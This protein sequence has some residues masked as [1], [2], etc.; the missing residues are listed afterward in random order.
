MQKTPG[1][2]SGEPRKGQTPSP[3]VQ[4]EI[5]GGQLETPE[6]QQGAAGMDVEGLDPGVGIPVDP[7]GSKSPGTRAEEKPGAGKDEARDEPE[8]EIQ[9][10][11]KE[12]SAPAVDAQESSSKGIPAG[13]T[14]GAIPGMSPSSEEAPVV[15]PGV[16][17]P[18]TEPAPPEKT[19]VPEAGKSSWETSTEKKAVPKSGDAPGKKW[20]VA[21]TERERT[22]EESIK[23][24]E[25]PG[26]IWGKAGTE[27]EKTPGKTSCKGGENSGSATGEIHVGSLVK[28]PPNKGMGAAKSDESRAAAPVNPAG[29]LKESCVGKTLLKAVVSVPDILKQRI[30]V[31]I[32]EPSLGKAGEQKIPPK[33]GLEKKIP[34]KAAAQPGT[35]NQWRGNGNSGMDAQGD[36]GK[37]SS[38]QEKDSQ[39]ESRGS[40]KQQGENGTSGTR[41]NAS[42]NQVRRAGIPVFPA[43][44]GSSLSL[45]HKSLGHQRS[46]WASTSF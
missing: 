26:K 25:N 3:N 21:G 39:L 14:P 1:N 20:D 5:P 8:L 2:P 42:R 12:P 29:A 31:R 32:S 34:G 17:Q 30:P 45:F 7:A 6:S 37:S 10:E 9:K 23:M 19:P 22:A 44:L 40:S 15:S 35:G 13:G 33:A 28:I 18:S 11:D 24:G 36:G 4:E 43:I 46:C 27:L 38:Q 41:E 16:T